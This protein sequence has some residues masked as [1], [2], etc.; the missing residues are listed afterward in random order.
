MLVLRRLLAHCML[1]LWVWGKVILM[2]AVGLI[3]LV[4]LRVLLVIMTWLLLVLLLL[5]YSFRV[6][7]ARSRRRRRVWCLR[8]GHHWLCLCHEWLW[9]PRLWILCEI[10]T[11]RQWNIGEDLGRIG[12]VVAR[13]LNHR[14]LSPY[15]LWFG[16]LVSRW[17]RF[18]ESIAWSGYAMNTLTVM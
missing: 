13:G 4:M 12:V 1:G 6:G 7:H 10:R 9:T 2:G 3:L 14:S 17:W 18:S 15:M 16:V 5:L 8:A 11:G